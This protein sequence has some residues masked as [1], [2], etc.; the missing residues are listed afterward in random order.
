[1]DSVV[2]DR[3]PKI[4]G[5]TS[6]LEATDNYVQGPRFQAECALQ[7]LR[8]FNSEMYYNDHE[9]GI[10]INALQANER[11]ARRKFFEDVITRRRRS[12]LAASR[13]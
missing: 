1:M 10:L 6:I 5:A 12:R 4:L 11:K 13:R 8:F 7:T 2:R 3:D 9:V